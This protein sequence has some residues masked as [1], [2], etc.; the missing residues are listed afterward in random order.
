MNNT[1]HFFSSPVNLERE[2][3]LKFGSKFNHGF[4]NHE[5]F[6]CAIIKALHD[7]KVTRAQENGDYNFFSKITEMKFLRSCMRLKITRNT[8]KQ[9]VKL[10]QKLPTEKTTPHSWCSYV[11]I[12]AGHYNSVPLK[13]LM[14]KVI[15]VVDLD[16]F[17]SLKVNCSNTAGSSSLRL[18]FS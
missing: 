5:C 11:F 17:N 3:N 8:T 2:L 10:I 12:I 18:I 16:I 6:H 4:T 9:S 1:Q 7:F 13:L 15:N 14:V